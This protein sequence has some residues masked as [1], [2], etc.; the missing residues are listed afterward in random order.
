MQIGAAAISDNIQNNF[1]AAKNKADLDQ[2]N[3]D[4]AVKL[5]KATQNP[6]DD[7]ETVRLK[8]VCRDMEA[9]FL[10]LMWTSMRA[11][12]PK[13]SLMSGGFSEDIMRSMM[14]TELT[15]KMAQA[16]GMGLADMIYRQLSGKT[17]NSVKNQASK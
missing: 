9:V 5:A 4:F 17:D 11:T 8:N 7:K 1:S 6:A 14:D 12:V 3:N 10:N 16:G 2:I 13:G 15:K